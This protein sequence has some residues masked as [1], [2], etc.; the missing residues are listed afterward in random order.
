MKQSKLYNDPELNQLTETIIGLAIE[1][2][3]HLGPGLLES[4]YESCLAYELTQHGLKV[5]R[6]KSLPIIYKKLT[7]EEGYRI[8]LL[9]E[10]KII[11]ELKAVEKL[12][13][14]H[15]AQILSYLK[16]SDCK[17]GLLFNFNVKILKTGFKRFMNF[18]LLKSK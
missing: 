12:T 7:L 2:H 1:V 18:K 14:V 8:D 4:A 3:R 17:V 6:Q 5:E 15:E 13:E 9:V 16:F 10:D 11:V